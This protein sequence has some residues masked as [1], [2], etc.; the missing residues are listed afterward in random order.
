MMESEKRLDEVQPGT[1]LN[2][3][4]IDHYHEV[5]LIGVG[6]HYIRMPT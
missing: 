4:I 6:C 2:E 3:G 1:G 5:G